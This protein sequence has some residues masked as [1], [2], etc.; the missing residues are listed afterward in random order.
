MA[1][2][3]GAPEMRRGI[4]MPIINRFADLHDEIESKSRQLKQLGVEAA[5]M[6][7]R[8]HLDRPYRDRTNRIGELSRELS[9]LRS[10]LATDEAV[11][12]SL[13]DYAR[14]LR[15]GDR[16]PLRAHISRAHRPASDAQLRTSRVAEAWA[17][18]SV[19][20]LLISLVG[21]V[22]LLAIVAVLAMLPGVVLPVFTSDHHPAKLAL[23]NRL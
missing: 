2:T 22:L 11:S 14:R 19:G 1:T 23:A 15:N 9:Q 6:R 10:R 3:F 4:A 16:G 17:A 13:G 18:V 21:I 8:S 12:E 5:A 20:L 7:D